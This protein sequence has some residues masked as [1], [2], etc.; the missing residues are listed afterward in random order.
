MI[1]CSNLRQYP[2]VFAWGNLFFSSGF[3]LAPISTSFSSQ[4]DCISCCGYVLQIDNVK[5]ASTF[6]LQTPNMKIDP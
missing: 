5:I 1:A 3:L 4:Y 2:L 6:H